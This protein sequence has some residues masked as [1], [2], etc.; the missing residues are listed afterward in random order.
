MGIYD[1]GLSCWERNKR[2]LAPENAGET[3]VELKSEKVEGAKGEVVVEAKVEKPVEKA[4]AAKTEVKK[5]FVDKVKGK[6]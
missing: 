1:D 2:G 3:K 5:S 4:K 6:K